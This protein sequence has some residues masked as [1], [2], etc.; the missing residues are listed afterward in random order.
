MKL[1][2]DSQPVELPLP[3]E[4]GFPEYCRE[5][6]NWLLTRNRAIGSFLLDGKPML[7]VEQAEMEFAGAVVCEVRS[8]PLG[9]AMR[10]S[11]ATQVERI[12]AIEEQCLRLVTDALLAEASEIAVAW[13]DIWANIRQQIGLIPQLA[14]L[15]DLD[16]IEDLVAT[17]LAE[18]NST[19]RDIGD[20]LNRA[21]V[22]AFSDILEFRLVPW[23]GRF[24]DF[25]QQHLD[26]LEQ[27][28]PVSQ[29]G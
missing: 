15:L 7:T 29:A 17:R 27:R 12:A 21:D 23:L 8:V 28:M 19:M 14:G 18:F 26:S 2:V 16:Q 20:V 3:K 9:E 1:I 13:Q 22:V 24:K 4:G 25:I 5:L 6:M 11:L 10:V